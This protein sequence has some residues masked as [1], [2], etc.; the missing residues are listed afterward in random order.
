MA[1][2]SRKQF[3]G[4]L[5]KDPTTVLEEGAQLV[6]TPDQTV[7]MA[8]IGHVTSSY[9]SATL[10]HSIALGMLAGGR[11]RI[12]ETIYV[13]MPDGPVEVR[14]CKPIFYDPQGARLDG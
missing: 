13:P 4:L 3:V 10:G 9:P 8:P 7:P 12:G 5:T 11:A 6:A 14:V 2:P 1:D